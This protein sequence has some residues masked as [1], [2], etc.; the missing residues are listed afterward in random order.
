MCVFFFVA[1]RK[2][3]VFFLTKYAFSLDFSRFPVLLENWNQR[4]QMLDRLKRVV[5]TLTP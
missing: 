3:L 2:L 5:D 4:V 1:S